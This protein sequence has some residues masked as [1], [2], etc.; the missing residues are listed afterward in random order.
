MSGTICWG[1][2]GFELTAGKAPVAVAVNFDLVV[3]VSGS[4]PNPGATGP[5]GKGCAS[6]LKTTVI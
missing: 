2:W 1:R 6:V 4:F 3:A 5:T